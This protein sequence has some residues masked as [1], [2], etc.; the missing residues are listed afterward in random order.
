MVKSL[1]KEENGNFTDY[2]KELSNKQNSTMEK[3]KES[4]VDLD[5]IDDE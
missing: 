1:S 2:V 5:N 3:I 4:N